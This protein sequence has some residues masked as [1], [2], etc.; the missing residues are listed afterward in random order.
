LVKHYDNVGK[1]FKDPRLKAAFTF[2]NMYLGLSPYDAPATYSLLQY[3]ELA[4]GVWYPIGGMYAPILA[5]TAIAE[6]LGVRF[7]YNAE[8]TRI[9][10]S[11]GRV[12]QVHLKDGRTLQ[13]DL[14][15]G[16]ADLPYIYK[17]LLPD[18]DAAR[19][20]DQMLYNL[21]DPHVLLGRG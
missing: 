17:E 15:I 9:E 2:Q 14:Y 8:V 16:N 7:L 12:E 4:E 18:R 11:N 3:T 5:L 20:F 10:T 1:Y 6:K 13:A 19:K 21:L